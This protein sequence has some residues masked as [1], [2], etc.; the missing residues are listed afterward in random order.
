MRDLFSEVRELEE[1]IVH[2]DEVSCVAESECAVEHRRLSAW[3]T[4]LLEIKKA[5]L[6]LEVFF[7]QEYDLLPDEKNFNEECECGRCRKMAMVDVGEMMTCSNCGALR[8]KNET[9]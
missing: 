8:R 5:R 4:E 6:S 7:H 3:L 1:A 9:N 2:A